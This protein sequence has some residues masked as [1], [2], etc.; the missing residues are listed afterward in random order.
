MQPLEMAWRQ[1]LESSFLNEET[2]V[3]CYRLRFESKLE[4]LVLHVVA[5]CLP[6]SARGVMDTK[7]GLPGCMAAL[8][9]PD[10][11]ATD[12]LDVGCC[13]GCVFWSKCYW[14][15]EPSPVA[16]KDEWL[17]YDLV[18]QCRTMVYDGHSSMCVWGNR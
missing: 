10:M 9:D 12:P 7:L 8:R 11:M 18:S 13:S 5:A 14:S 1:V 6:L 15:S 4:D 17:E 16:E 2:V 3:Y